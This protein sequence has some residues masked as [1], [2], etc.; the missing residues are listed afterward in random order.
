MK[1]TADNYNTGFLVDDEVAGGVAEHPQKPGQFVAFI[2]QHTTGEYLGYQPF[3]TL[4]AALKTLNEVER[5]WVFE[6]ASSCSGGC[7]NHGEGEGHDH[8]HD[9]GH[10]GCGGGGC[11]GCGG[12]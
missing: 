2:L 12:H 9:H 7:G 11:G 8:G 10:G 6:K 5:E 3:D 4:E 1:L